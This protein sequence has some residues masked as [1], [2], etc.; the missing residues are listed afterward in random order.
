MKS[1]T[2]WVENQLIA[3]FWGAF[4]HT[5]AALQFNRDHIDIYLRMEAAR[6]RASTQFERRG[7]TKAAPVVGRWGRWWGRRCRGGGGHAL[8]HPQHRT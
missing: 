3:Y 8:H 5:I 7:A 4:V 2:L 6:R 1:S